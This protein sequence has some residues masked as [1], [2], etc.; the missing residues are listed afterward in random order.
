MTST[1]PRARLVD[2]LGGVAAYNDKGFQWLGHRAEDVR[3][4]RQ[5]AQRA[6]DRLVDEIGENAFSVDLLQKLRGGAAVT[7]PFG[8]IAEQAR[9]ELLRPS[10]RGK[11]DETPKP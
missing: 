11:S 4:H 8:V 3:S 1:D 10:P 9:A 2:H 5:Q 6:I 7:D